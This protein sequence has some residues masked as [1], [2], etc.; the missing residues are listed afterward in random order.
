[1]AGYISRPAR[2]SR[3]LEKSLRATSRTQR[4]RLVPLTFVAGLG[5][6]ALTGSAARAA[7][8]LTVDYS[9][10]IKL[11]TPVAVR[12]AMHAAG[13]NGVLLKGA[14]ALDALARVDSM[15][16]DKTGTLT[17]GVLTVT[18]VQPLDG[19]TPDE[20]LA[21]AAGAEEHYGHPVARAVFQAAQDQGLTLPRIS[22]V[23]FIVAHGVSA[24]VEGLR[25]LVGSRHFIHED[26]SV[27]CS[28]ADQRADELRAQGKTLLYVAHDEQLV[29]LIGLRDAPRPEA[30]AVLRGLKALGVSRLVMLTGDHPRSA[31][32]I[33]GLLPELDEV[34]AGL[35]P[36]EKAGLVREMRHQGLH[37]AF[38][39][40][41]VNDSPAL[42]EAEVGI[43]M[44]M[45]ADLARD[46]AQVVLMRDD[47]HGLAYALNI[48][49]RTD[50]VLHRC[51]WSAVGVNTALMGLAG[52]GI[53]PTLA[54]ATLHNS[55]TVGILA[56]AATNK[57]ERHDSD[58]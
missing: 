25:V 34:H 27:D 10:A 48:A 21:L 11:A 8:V 42:L 3:F 39:G 1:M 52:A 18:D 51:L 26:E 54:S 41:G 40:D 50:A 30:A 46:A 47:L 58:S 24:H 2:I 23:D 16:F 15:V 29:G 35:R 4:H 13:Q 33:A 12:T 55:T 22:R 5:M 7:S 45:A 37:P 20:L 28:A 53:L 49:R 36:E 31:Q 44:P 38:V 43:C 56:Y 14:Q 6:Y 9:C 19:R 32:A 57:G 17:Q